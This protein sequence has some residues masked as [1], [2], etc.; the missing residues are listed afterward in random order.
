[1]NNAIPNWYEIGQKVQGGNKIYSDKTIIVVHVVRYIFNLALRQTVGFIKGYLKNIGKNL[2][3]ISFSQ[4]SRRLSQLNLK[5]ID[6]RKDKNS[7]DDIE[8]A[9]DSTSINIYDNGCC[10]ERRK[11]KDK[12]RKYSGYDQVR[13]L[14]AIIDINSKKVV[15]ARYSSGTYSDHS[16]ACDLLKSTN[17]NFKTLYADR[18]YD[19]RKLY[20]LCKEIGIKPII[21]PYVNAYFYP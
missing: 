11:N 18:A 2:Q 5:I 8:I 4:A 16:G 17:N 7:I 14:H 12:T 3:I 15:A 9:I 1:M 13:K 6:N 10:H 21:P 20:K 19:R